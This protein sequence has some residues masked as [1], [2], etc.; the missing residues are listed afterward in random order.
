MKECEYCFKNN[1]RHEYNAHDGDSS[2]TI[3]VKDEDGL[4]IQINWYD[5]LQKQT[6]GMATLALI[7]YCPWCGR[8]L[9]E[10]GNDSSTT[11]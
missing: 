10:E 1:I 5:N 3:K 11:N 9:G 4:Y 2:I 7:R 8:K 6:M